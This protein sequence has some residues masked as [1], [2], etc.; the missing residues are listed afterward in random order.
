[1]SDVER[2]IGQVEL[3]PLQPVDQIMR[4][5]IGVRLERQGLEGL[6]AGDRLMKCD[7]IACARRTRRSRGAGAATEDHQRA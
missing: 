1:L 2:Q 5:L 7:S 4:V 6:D 3:T